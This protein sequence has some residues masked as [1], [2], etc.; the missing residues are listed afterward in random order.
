MQ[1]EDH[2]GDILR[3]A[4]AGRGVAS[5]PAAAAAG[6]SADALQE[7]EASGQCSTQPDYT[8]L[9]DLLNLNPTKLAGIANGWTPAEPDLEQ[10][11][12]LRRLTTHAQGMDVHCYLVWDEV[13][14]E[15]ALFDTGWSAEPAFK[16]IQQEQLNLTHLFVTH[17]HPD[18]IADLDAVRAQHPKVRLHTDTADAL[19][20]HKNR[21]NDCVHVGSLRITNRPTPGHAGDGVTYLVGNWPED[22]PHVAIVGD[23]IFAGS[24]G[25]AQACFEEARKH[26]REQILVLPDPTLI[27]PGHGPLTT[28]AEEKANNP[29][30]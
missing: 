29:F 3:K 18:H 24:M 9:A 4:R 23:A 1:L 27:C 25:G 19:P 6:V 15:A 16:L 26:V 2:L 8:K 21:R 14:R 13:T 17:S 28:V 5:Q 11:R 7:L 12:E 20:Q 10:W 22:A 30:F